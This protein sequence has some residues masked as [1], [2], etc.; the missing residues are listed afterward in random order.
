MA[1]QIITVTKERLTEYLG[2]LAPDELRALDMALR[3]QL[4]LAA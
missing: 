4:G 2:L 1:D 3:I